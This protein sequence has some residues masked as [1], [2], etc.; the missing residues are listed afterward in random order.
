MSIVSRH[1]LSLMLAV[2]SAIVFLARPS[3]AQSQEGV[4]LPPDTPPFS[5]PFDQ[6]PGPGTWYVSQF[7]GN[8]QFAYEYGDR[9]YQAGQGLHFGLDFDA[10]CGTPDRK[11]TRLNSS[12]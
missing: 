8:T 11:S 1:C 7:Y 3:M 6:P 5:L 2:A 12:H 4:A 10:K 9:W